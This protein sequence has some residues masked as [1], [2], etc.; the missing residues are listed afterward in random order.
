MGK[1]DMKLRVVAGGGSGDGPRPLGAGIDAGYLSRFE[2][3]KLHGFRADVVCSRCDDKKWVEV[4]VEDGMIR[5][6]ECGE[7]HPLERLARI[8]SA[9]GIPARYRPRRDRHGRYLRVGL[10]EYGAAYEDEDFVNGAYDSAYTWTREWI[11]SGD[12]EKWLYVMGS[13]RAATALV[14]AI[15]NDILEAGVITPEQMSEGKGVRY[16]SASR[17]LDGLRTSYAEQTKPVEVREAAERPRLL[18]L[19][20]LGNS[21]EEKA[22]TRLAELLRHRD[23]ELLPTIFV[24]RYEPSDLA[25]GLG[26]EVSGILLD[27]CDVLD[28][29][30]GDHR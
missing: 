24:S 26:D 16:E 10:E 12:P 14:C 11:D 25:V 30:G 29:Q 1:D 4:E 15:A 23:G 17:L 27:A 19:D 22:A 3:V 8:G 20:G 9:A 5:C 2:K 7:E 13:G 21:A 6:P 28:M 18:I